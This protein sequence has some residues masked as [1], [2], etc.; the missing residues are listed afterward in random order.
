[1]AVVKSEGFLSSPNNG[2]FGNVIRHL[3]PLIVTDKQP[4]K[5]LDILDETVAEMA[6]ER[7]KWTDNL[8][9]IYSYQKEE[10]DE[11][12]KSKNAGSGSRRNDPFFFIGGSG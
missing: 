5:G 8:R 10:Q 3:G 2:G 7:K 9:A 1:L 11:I 4:E 12:G 6:N